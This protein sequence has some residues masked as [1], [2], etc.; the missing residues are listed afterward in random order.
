[1]KSKSNQN[2]SFRSY[3]VDE[4]GDGTIFNRRGRVIVGREGCSRFFMLGLLDVSE[5]TK[6]AKELTALHT[7]I[8]SDPYLKKIPSLQPEAKKTSLA[9]HAKDDCQEVRQQVFKLIVQHELKFFALVRD[10]LAIAS[11]VKEHNKK[12][13]SYRYHPNQL[14]DR[15]TS[16]IFRDRLHKDDGY[17]IYF[18]KRG[19]KDR[20]E[21]L[22]Q[23]LENARRNF[24]SK[25]EIDA[26]S[27]I[28][29]VSSNPPKTPLLQVADYLLWALQ[30]LYERNED[31]YWDYVSSKASLIHDVDDTSLKEYGEYY[32]KRN[33]ISIE[34][35]KER[36]KME[37][38]K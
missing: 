18:A 7:E 11:K 24:R 35:I 30:R 4:A 14:Y 22:R 15:C 26:T 1:M 20:T 8:L 2:S 38:N 13:P 32:D 27:P 36:L 37:G 9:F 31:R 3:F 10:K 6:L 34:K 28:E 23:S 5:P 21:A 25:Y 12:S 16:R 33:P 29:I 17:V 19:S